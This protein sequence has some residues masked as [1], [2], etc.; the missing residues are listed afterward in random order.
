MLETP[1]THLPFLDGIRGI[2]IFAVFLF[3]SLG[4]SFGYDHLEWNGLFR[5]FDAAPSFL[6]LYPFTYGSAGVAVF[7]VVS[8]FCI[9]LSYK[10][11]SDKSWLNFSNR[12]FFRIYPP[13][14]L[15]L[16]VFFFIWPWGSFNIDNFG[17]LKQLVTHL[18]SVHNFDQATY[19]GIN[20]S[21]WSIATE[22]QLYAIYPLLLLLC[23]KI[24]WRKGMVVVAAIEILIRLYPL[25]AQHSGLGSLPRFISYSPF[26]YWLS[27]SLGAYLYECHSMNVKSRLFSIRFD[28]ILL[29]AFLVPM[30][31]PTQ[32]FSFPAFSLVTAVAIDR[33]IRSK[34]KFPD[35]RV[36]RCA[37]S[38]LS[39]LG[40][41]SYSFYL[42]HQPFIG[43]IRRTAERFLQG[44]ALHPIIYY[45]ACLCLYPFIL[46]LSYLAFKFVEMPSIQLGKIVWNKY[47][48]RKKYPEL[49]IDRP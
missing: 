48:K 22:I 28:L 26:A 36:T 46:I 24:G 47:Q 8:G 13:Y 23:S 7:F 17:R 2:A 42:F 37:W 12:R 40:V 18:F 19:F 6:A 44:D 43:L 38:H 11:S 1:K 25:L 34:W 4:A 5:N 14:L 49:A 3:H 10:R 33:L 35:S 27:W 21:F 16:L 29:L 30:F 20:P 15:A 45:A 31:K 41:I 32:A 39:F 9:H